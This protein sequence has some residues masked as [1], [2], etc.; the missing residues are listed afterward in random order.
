MAYNVETAKLAGKGVHRTD[1][2][3]EIKN[4]GPTE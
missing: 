4:I 1:S 3:K 2:Q